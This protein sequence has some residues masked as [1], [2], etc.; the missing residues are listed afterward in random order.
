MKN[1]KVF[2][3][4]LRICSPDQTSETGEKAKEQISLWAQVLE[5][6]KKKEKQQAIEM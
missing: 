4:R 5:E 1:W 2:E 3:M 6:E